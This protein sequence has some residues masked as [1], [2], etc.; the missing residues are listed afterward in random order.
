M[1]QKHALYN[2]F[3]FLTW[4]TYIS[5]MFGHNDVIILQRHE[6]SKAGGCF[7]IWND[8]Q[9]LFCKI[10]EF[11]EPSIGYVLLFSIFSTFFFWNR[12]SNGSAHLLLNLLHELGKTIRCEALP[13]IL[14]V[15]PNEFKKFNDT[16]ARIQDS[17]YHMTLKSHFISKFCTKK[18]R[19]RH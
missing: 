16:G 7:I 6:R 17:I 11:A 12:G 1:T 3:A 10:R 19:F 9:F 5:Y 13:S 4:S 8:V 2:V 18:S 14:W 15:F